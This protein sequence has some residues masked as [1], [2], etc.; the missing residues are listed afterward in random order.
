MCFHLPAGRCAI[1]VHSHTCY[2]LPSAKCVRVLLLTGAHVTLGGAPF[3]CKI[4]RRD[5]LHTLSRTHPALYIPNLFVLVHPF[6]RGTL[7]CLSCLF[8]SIPMSSAILPPA[9]VLPVAPF[10][11]RRPSFCCIVSSSPTLC[12]TY[13]ICSS[14]AAHIYLMGDLVHGGGVRPYG[15][16][17]STLLHVRN[18]WPS[19]AWRWCA[20]VDWQVSTHG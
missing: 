6:F 16:H 4:Y 15:R 20:S 2:F 11:V 8:A 10:V 3:I 1:C 7:C 18:F 5:V 17:I 19:R 14:S 9:L 12:S 13:S